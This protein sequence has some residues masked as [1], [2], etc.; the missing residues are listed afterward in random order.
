MLMI[1]LDVFLPKS[2]DFLWTGA[3]FQLGKLKKVSTLEQGAL[4]SSTW[5][6]NGVSVGKLSHKFERS[7]ESGKCDSKSSAPP[8]LR[9]RTASQDGNGTGGRRAADAQLKPPLSHLLPFPKS[10]SQKCPP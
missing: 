5:Q 4:W 7:M 3:H 2:E 8:H 9:A 6:D 10:L 1:L